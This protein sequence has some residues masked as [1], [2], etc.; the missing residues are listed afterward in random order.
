MGRRGRPPPSG[1]FVSRRVATDL[2][3]FLEHPDPKY[4]GTVQTE[5]NDPQNSVKNK[6]YLSTSF[7]SDKNTENLTASV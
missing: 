1:D 3:G 2:C 5:R 7:T 4:G 6:T